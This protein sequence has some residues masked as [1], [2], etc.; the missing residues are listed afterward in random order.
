M[1]AVDE[2]AI[3]LQGKG[4]H[5]A[6]PHL[7][8]DAIPA[9][10]QLVLALQ[11]MVSRETD[12]VSAAVVSVT[13]V[14]AGSG[15]VNVISGMAELRGTVRSFSPELRDNLE[16]R[17][18]EVAKSIANT[19]RLSCEVEYIRTIDP[20]LNHAEATSFCQ[21]AAAK[22]VGEENVR[23]IAPILGGEDFGAFLEAR[24]G[25]FIAIGQAEEDSTSPH[26]FGLHSPNYDFNDRILPIAAGYF[27]ELAETRLP[28]D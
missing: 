13:N 18:K 16:S 6:M 15:A 23:E 26:N 10:A 24:P 20:V 9:A 28:V 14:A 3:R 25:A 1:A 21:T 11:T 22:I 4:G 19:F 17:I 27:A 7:T 8:L 12:P 5:A 2:F